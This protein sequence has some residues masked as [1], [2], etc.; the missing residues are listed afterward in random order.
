MGQEDFKTRTADRIHTDKVQ[1]MAEAGEKERKEIAEAGH[2]TSKFVDD[3]ND[4]E[5]RAG[6]KYEAERLKGL[7][8]TDLRYLL[9]FIHEEQANR[10]RAEEEQQATNL[11]QE[12][13]GKM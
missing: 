3:I 6:K 5:Y 8:D 4:A 12:I 10:R 2:D 13:K 1:T 9:R 11:S 7:S